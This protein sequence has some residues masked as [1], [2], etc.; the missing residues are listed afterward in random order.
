MKVELKI[1]KVELET[2]K[3]NPDQKIEEDG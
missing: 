2:M 3:G 1:M